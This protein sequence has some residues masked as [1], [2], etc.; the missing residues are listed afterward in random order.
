MD[1][2]IVHRHSDVT[3][4]RYGHGP[5]GALRDQSVEVALR[6]RHV[7]VNGRLDI[8]F[9]TATKTDCEPFDSLTAERVPLRVKTVIRCVL[10]RRQPLQLERER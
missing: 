1:A 7:L 8:D 10:L 2:L 3:T 9:C 6:R 4:V 5:G